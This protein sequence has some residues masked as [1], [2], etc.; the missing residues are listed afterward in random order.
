M[1]AEDVVSE[2]KKSNAVEAAALCGSFRQGIEDRHSDMDVWIFLE[3][4]TELS[5]RLV[6]EK[7]LSPQAQSLVIEEGRDD[8]HVDYVVLNLKCSDCILNL[9]FLG[10]EQLADFTAKKPSLDTAYMDDLENYWTMQILYDRLGSIGQL[11]KHLEL[12]SIRRVGDDLYP[13]MLHRYASFYWRSVFQGVLRGEMNAWRGLMLYL[14][15]LLIAAAYLKNDT[16]PPSK[17]WILTTHAVQA[18]GSPAPTLAAALEHVW[19]ADATDVA[20]ML[21][22]YRDL[23]EAEVEIFD[24]D[25]LPQGF[26][27][28]R[29]FTER[30]PNIEADPEIQS[31]VREALNGFLTGGTP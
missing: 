31:A 21:Q 13:E 5:V 27:W 19:A 17:K 14:I 7:I 9:K 18:T 26:W 4:G 29:V 6:V 30:L 11:R 24:L 10:L 2:L 3:I 16:L 20:S 1:H 28:R 12:H 23:S 15:E 22:V 8:T 25:H